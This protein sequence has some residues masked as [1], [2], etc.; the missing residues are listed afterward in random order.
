MKF[1]L[2][3]MVGNDPMLEDPY[4]AISTDGTRLLMIS[5]DMIR[6]DVPADS[7]ERVALYDVYL[8]TSRFIEYDMHILEE[9]IK[10][11]TGQEKFNFVAHFKPQTEHVGLTFPS[12]PDYKNWQEYIDISHP[13]PI[14]RAIVLEVYQD[15]VS[16]L[17]EV[18]EIA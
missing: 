16:I 12:P 10:A 8:P 14:A 3:T 18:F 7:F 15:M 1:Q 4:C 13:D 5:E 9:M 11:Y 6:F 17:H 2:F